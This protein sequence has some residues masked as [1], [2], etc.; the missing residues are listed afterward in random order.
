MKNKYTVLSLFDGMS[1]GQVALGEAGIKVK[2][3]YASEIDKSAITITQKNHPNTIQLGSVVDLKKKQLR[4]LFKGKRVVLM[5]GSPCQGFSLAG[6]ML[7]ASTSCGIDVTS[8]KQYLKLKKEGFAFDGQSYL[9]WEYVRIM[10]IVKPEF[11]FLENVRVTKKW[12]PMFNKAMGVS[13][14]MINSAL[15]T[16]Q[17]RE[18]YYW[19]NI[20][21]E[22]PHDEHLYIDDFLQIKGVRVG[23]PQ[24]HPRNYL[25]LGLPRKERMEFRTDRKSN[26]LLPSPLKNQI[27]TPDGLRVLTVSECE[28]LQTL[29][30]N[31]TNGVSKT[32]RYKMIGSG[33]T[34][35]V[36]S[37][38]F[39]GLK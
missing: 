28:R 6:K 33:W 2:K 26:T 19:T 10:R 24:A 7:G 16:P 38:I 27:E 22:L 39:K 29:P 21:F 23:Q 8:L 34:V 15:M 3:Y 11:F 32:Q 37:H 4:K 12:L 17:N 18:R 31:Y 14:V 13:E 30:L 9:F 20:P 36:I 25:E 35:K 1:C 5:G